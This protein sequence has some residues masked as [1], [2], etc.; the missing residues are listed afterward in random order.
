MSCLPEK[1]NQAVILH[2]T[3][4]VDFQTIFFIRP[5]LCI[6]AGSELERIGCEFRRSA[7]TG[8]ATAFPDDDKYRGWPMRLTKTVEILIWERH[9]WVLPFHAHP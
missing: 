7:A 2:A 1:R 5:C 3:S 6:I 4:L 9:R 8:L